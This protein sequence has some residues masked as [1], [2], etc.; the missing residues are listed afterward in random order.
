MISKCSVHIHRNEEEVFAPIMSKVILQWV[1]STLQKLY[2]HG[3]SGWECQFKYQST[4]TQS[5]GAKVYIP[6]T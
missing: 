6:T 2:L 4:P 3:E 1:D 5:I